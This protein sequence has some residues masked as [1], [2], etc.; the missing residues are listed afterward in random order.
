MEKAFGVVMG[1]INCVQNQWRDSGQIDKLMVLDKTDHS[2]CDT[3]KLSGQITM[4][5]KD[6]SLNIKG[7]QLS[8]PAR[9]QDVTVTRYTT[10]GGE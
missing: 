3:A 5:C 10:P 4:W 9:E 8:R 1:D 2:K 7:G 6:D